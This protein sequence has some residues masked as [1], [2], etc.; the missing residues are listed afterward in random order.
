ML[1]RPG[2]LSTRTS[3]PC[4]VTM[5][6][7]MARPIPVPGCSAASL[8]RR[9]R[10][11]GRCHAVRAARRRGRDRA[12]G[13]RPRRPLRSTVT[14]TVRQSGEYLTALSSRFH[15]ALVNASRSPWTGT[16]RYQHEFHRDTA[17]GTSR[18]NSST[19][20]EPTRQVER[21]FSIR[22][23]AGLHAS[24]IEQ[25]LHQPMQPVGLSRQR[26]K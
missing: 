1:P 16:A 21:L 12:R 11:S 13:S 15:S 25:A 4:A 22:R 3:P 6:W 17:S 24:E 19:P 9:A 8:R 18:L 2:S 10:I 23:R 14:H 20:T 7:T 5:C 26:A